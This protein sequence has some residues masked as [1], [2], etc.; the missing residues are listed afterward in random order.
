MS[1]R[2]WLDRAHKA[3]DEAVAAA[4]GWSVDLSDEEILERL[5]HLNQERSAEQDGTN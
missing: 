5:F 3:L 1:A 4:Y 2:L